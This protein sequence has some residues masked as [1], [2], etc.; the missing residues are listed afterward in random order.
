MMLLSAAKDGTDNSDSERTTSHA[1][2]GA[3]VPSCD[4]NQDRKGHS[5]DHL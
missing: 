5:P 1:S 3:L 2:G 4:L